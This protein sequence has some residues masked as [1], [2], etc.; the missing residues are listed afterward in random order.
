MRHFAKKRHFGKKASLRLENFVLDSRS[1]FF[2]LFR[3]SD[4]LPFHTQ[5][6]FG[7]VTLVWRSDAYPTQ[8]V[9]NDSKIYKRGYS[10]NE[11]RLRVKKYVP[12]F[13]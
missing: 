1:R 6:F 7:E 9:F 8:L 12:M 11:G 10:S 4:F 3:S 5:L 2:F 13:V